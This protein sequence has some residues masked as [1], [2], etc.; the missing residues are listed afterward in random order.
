MET[1]I[2]RF[3]GNLL[4]TLTLSP[5]IFSTASETVMESCYRAGPDVMYI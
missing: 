2:V 4:K 1:T 5:T 3:S